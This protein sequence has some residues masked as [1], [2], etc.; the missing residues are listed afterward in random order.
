MGSPAFIYLSPGIESL[1][2]VRAELALRDIRCLNRL[3][4][5]ADRAGLIGSIRLAH[6]QGGLCE[7]EF[8]I[9]RAGAA[10]CWIHAR[11]HP[12][13]DVNGERVWTGVFSDV[14]RRKETEAALLASEETFRTLFETVPQGIVYFHGDGQIRVANPA[15]QRILGLSRDQLESRSSLDPGWQAVHEDGAEFPG[16]QH[17]SMVAIRTGRPVR[18]VVMGLP[19]PN[20]GFVWIQ[21]NATP[22]HRNGRLAEVYASFEDITERVLLAQELKRQAATDYLTGAANRRCL[23][24]RLTQ[25][26]ERVRRHSQLSCSLLSLD[27]DHFKQVNDHWGHAAGDS[28]LRHVTR[29][30]REATRLVDLVSRSGGEEFTLL[31]PDTPAGAAMALAERLREQISVQPTQHQGQAI[32]LTVSIGVTAIQADDASPDVVLSRADQALYQAKHA[33]RNTVRQA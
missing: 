5:K 12:G 13:V 6:A 24:E 18:D 7:H 16:D 3:V 26:F 19:V 20:N 4:L 1:L 25:E 30:M 23:M 33:G 11:V 17:P 8:R 22:I 14:S 2:G 9:Q 15:A 28:V 10:P 21:V 29:L 32:A 27:L 31:L